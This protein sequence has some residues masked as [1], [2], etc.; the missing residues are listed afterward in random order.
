MQTSNL[1]I[2]PKTSRAIPVRLPFRRDFLIQAA[3]DGCVRRIEYHPAMRV[4]YGIARIDGII[5]DSDEG[6]HAVDFVEARPDCDPNGENLMHLAFSEGCSG[7]MVVTEADIRREPRFSSSRQVWQHRAVRLRADDRVEVLTALE[8]EGPVPIRALH[9]LTATTRDV[10]D[11]VFALACT[12][13]VEIDLRHPLND[14]T[15]VRIGSRN[16]V[17]PGRVAFGA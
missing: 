6:R 17:P 4:D 9:G 5:I 11:I 8:T 10:T 12:G 16:I 7:I 1:F 13:E 3:L 14:R 2:G 15:V